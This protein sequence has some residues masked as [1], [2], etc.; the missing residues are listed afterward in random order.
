MGMRIPLL[1]LKITL[2][3]NPLKSRILVRR[4][5]VDFGS[6]IVRG[7]PSPRAGELLGARPAEL[8]MELYIYIYIYIYTYLFI[9][10]F[11]VFLFIIIYVYR[12]LS[13]SLYIY[14][15]IYIYI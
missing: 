3:S 5:A 15:Y 11:I 12:S 1:K 13:L 7:R 10:L 9:Y 4:L 8:N 14:I 6:L 2:E